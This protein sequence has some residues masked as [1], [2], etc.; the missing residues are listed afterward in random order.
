MITKIRVTL[1]VMII[2]ND[3]NDKLV[4]K[5]IDISSIQPGGIDTFCAL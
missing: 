5:K 1:T 4:S 2:N 3:K